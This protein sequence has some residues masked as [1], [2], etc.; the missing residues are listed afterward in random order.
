M[1]NKEKIIYNKGDIRTFLLDN[2]SNLL[3]EVY[4]QSAEDESNKKSERVKLKIKKDK[5]GQTVSVDG[6]KWGRKALPRR[7]I[8]EVIKYKDEKKSMRWI[9]NNVYYYDKNN[10]KTTLSVGSVHKIVSKNSGVCNK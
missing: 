5:Y 7:V 4:A 6:K 1:K 10:N 2:I 8:E 9:A 3:L